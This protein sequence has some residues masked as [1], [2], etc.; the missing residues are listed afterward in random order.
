MGARGQEVVRAAGKVSDP[1]DKTR[2][3]ENQCGRSRTLQDTITGLEP[4]NGG[5]ACRCSLINC[6][7]NDRSIMRPPGG[8]AQHR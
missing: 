1:G 6:L 3:K 2:E 7:I 5:V 4:G 8:H